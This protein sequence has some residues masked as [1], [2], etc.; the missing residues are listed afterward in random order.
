MK[1]AKENN[2]DD[3]DYD[4]DEDVKIDSYVDEKYLSLINDSKK[5]KGDRHCKRIKRVWH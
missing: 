1:H 5:Y 3:P 4:V 2:A